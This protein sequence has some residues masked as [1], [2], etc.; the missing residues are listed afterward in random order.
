LRGSLTA[1]VLANRYGGAGT[2]GS[3]L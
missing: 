2:A 1:A 3:E